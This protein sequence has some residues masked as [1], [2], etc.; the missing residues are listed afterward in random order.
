MDWNLRGLGVTAPHKTALMK[1]LDYVEPSAAEIGAIN[2]IVVEGEELHGFNTDVTAFISTL[3]LMLKSVR[4]LR[5]A[6]IG[7]GGAARAVLW[8]LRQEGAQAFVFAR[9]ADGAQALAEKF[10]AGSAPLAQAKFDG[11]DVVINTTPLGTRG[12][13][14]GLTPARANQLRGA[15]LAYD[16]V[17]NP[18]ETRFIREAQEAG[19]KTAGGLSMLV[20]QAAE[21]FQ[22]WT[23]VKAPVELM[24]KAAQAA[25]GA[26]PATAVGK[27]TAEN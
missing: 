21:Q 7:A 2:T 6:V 11:F 5:C 13:L 26:S 22:M 16:L 20:A 12:P 8:G 17:Y 9:D 23:G 10:G 25:I 4:G 19:C 1:Q 3:R 24:H 18:L 27:P 14:E 15:H